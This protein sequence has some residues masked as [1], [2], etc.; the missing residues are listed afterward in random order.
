MIVLALA[1][2]QPAYAA[3]CDKSLDYIS[4]DLAGELPQP[5]EAYRSLF[6]ACQQALEIDNVRDTYLLRDGGIA[7]VPKRA[8]VLATAKTLA[9]FCR[10]FPRSKLRFISRGEQRR[11][12]TPGLVVLTSSSNVEPC[13]QIPARATRGRL[14]TASGAQGRLIVVLFGVSNVG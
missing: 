5:A 12:L 9:A 6:K 13:A 10:Q 11:G 2:A 7:V 4:N 8:S 14:R 3:S 1:F